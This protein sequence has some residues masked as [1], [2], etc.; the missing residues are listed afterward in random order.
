[1]GH[2]HKVTCVRL[3]NEEKAVVTGSADCTIKIWDISRSTYRQNLN[4]QYPSI[5]NCIDIDVDASIVASGHM[6]GTLILWDIRSD[7]KISEIS[8]KRLT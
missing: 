8:G 4:F 5:P 1:M 7:E 3:F 6:D 2:Q